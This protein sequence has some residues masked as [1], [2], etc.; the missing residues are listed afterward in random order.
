[1]RVHQL[2][3]EYDKKS[4]DFLKEIQGYGI[5]AS[6]HL[7]G[8]S[9]DEVSLI[10]QNIETKKIVPKLENEL[11]ERQVKERR[12]GEFSTFSDEDRLEG[13][14]GESKI[15]IN[16]IEGS[17]ISDVDSSEEEPA[18]FDIEA[19][20]LT[21]ETSEDSV[22]ETGKVGIPS[23]EVQ[24]ALATNIKT[25][26]QA[27]EEYAKT[28]KAIV[29]DPENWHVLDPKTGESMHKEPTDDADSELSF[30]QKAFSKAEKDRVKA[31]REEEIKAKEIL[32]AQEVIVE[33][34]SGFFGWLK[35]LFS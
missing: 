1:M 35:G 18:V 3:K 12:D 21:G 6:S 24:E 13:F 30:G 14:E 22:V 11:L 15:T 7:S 16:K 2:A 19:K 8:L 31:L 32:K 29:E 20:N 5:I 34:P 27:R 9:D 26:G 23:E 4:S 17:E 10:R 33:K 25:A 28:S